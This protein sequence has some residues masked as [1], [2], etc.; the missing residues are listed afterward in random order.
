MHSRILLTLADTSLYKGVLEFG[1]V[2]FPSFWGQRTCGHSLGKAPC[3]NEPKPKL[4]Y[5]RTHTMQSTN[6]HQQVVWSSDSWR[7][8]S[9]RSSF[10]HEIK[11]LTTA[12]CL[13]FFFFLSSRCDNLRNYSYAEKWT[14]GW[15]GSI[16]NESD[17]SSWWNVH[18]AELSNRHSL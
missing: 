12:R 16:L 18:F 6:P 3:Q 5:P 11:S 1:L 8:P 9:D 17:K 14:L 13:G 2:W 7:I 4:N 10:H 15:W